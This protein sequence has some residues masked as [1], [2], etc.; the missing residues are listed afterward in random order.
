MSGFEVVS[1]V[2]THFHLFAEPREDAPPCRMACIGDGA[3]NLCMFEIVPARS[4]AEAGCQKVD[5]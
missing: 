5:Q 2:S 4:L 1:K 3:S